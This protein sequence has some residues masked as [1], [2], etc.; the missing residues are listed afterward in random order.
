M[1]QEIVQE[2]FV[3]VWQSPRTPRELSGFRPW[4]Y[5]TIVNLVRDHQRKRRRWE[6]LRIG[7]GESADPV[8]EVERRQADAELARA[9]RHLS[10]RE[11]EAVYVRFFEDA[12]YEEVARIVGMRSGAARVLVHRALRKL[13]RQLAA[14]FLGE[15]VLP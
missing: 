12:S 4:L 6:H 9:I 10:R 15:L 2:A 3:R 1:A 8:D 5:K 7:R 11:R 13:R 14:H